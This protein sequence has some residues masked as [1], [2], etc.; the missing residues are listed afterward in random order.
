MMT[1]EEVA[2]RLKLSLGKIRKDK[3]SGLLKH[4]KFGGAIRVSEEQFTTYLALHRVESLRP[5][6]SHRKLR[7]IDV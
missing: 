4:Y 3:D 6:R 1:L 7:N 5:R 2:E